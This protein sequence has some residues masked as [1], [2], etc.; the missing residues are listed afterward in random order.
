MCLFFIFRYY[1][2][3]WGGNNTAVHSSIVKEA[4]PS[5]LPSTFPWTVTKIHKVSNVSLL[6]MCWKLVLAML[7]LSDSFCG[8]LLWSESRVFK[9][10][11]LNFSILSSQS[12]AVLIKGANWNNADCLKKQTIPKCCS[13]CR[14]LW[15]DICRVRNDDNQQQSVYFDI[16]LNDLDLDSYS[17]DLLVCCCYLSVRWT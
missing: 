11:K 17:F 9:Q 15:T 3:V 5:L 6:F 14:C 10:F 12:E 4:S 13:I 8:T 16:S 1:S 7:K 2:V